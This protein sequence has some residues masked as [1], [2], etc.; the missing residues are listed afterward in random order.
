[1]R[2]TT[3]KAILALKKCHVDIRINNIQEKI[4]VGEIDKKEI[5]ELNSLTKIKTNIAKIMGRNIG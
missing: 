4:N 1:M 2:K 3:E 5:E